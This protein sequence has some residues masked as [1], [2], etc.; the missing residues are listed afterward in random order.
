M[1]TRFYFRRLLNY[2]TGYVWE[3]ILN[4]MLAQFR[5]IYAATASILAFSLDHCNDLLEGFVDDSQ[6]HH[7]H[8]VH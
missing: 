6:Y 5:W 3:N 2:S 7:F 1:F 8:P 4:F